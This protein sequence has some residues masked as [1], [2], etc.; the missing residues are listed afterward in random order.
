MTVQVEKMIPYKEE[1]P[2]E[3]V[4]E[5]PVPIVLEKEVVKQVRVLVEKI[6]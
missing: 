6:V 3:V 2:V 1:V 5:V 4:R